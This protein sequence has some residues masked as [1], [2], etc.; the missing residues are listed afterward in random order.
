M[1][2]LIGASN[3]VIVLGSDNISSYFNDASVS[4]NL[5]LKS[6]LATFTD[7]AAEY[8]PGLPGGDV[9][10]TGLYDDTAANIDGILAV[11]FATAASQAIFIGPATAAVGKPCRY[12]AVRAANHQYPIGVSEYTKIVARVEADG[13]LFRGVVHHALTAETTTVNGAAQDNGAASTSGGRVGLWVTAATVTTVTAKY[14][15]SA[16]GSTDWQDIATFTTI[17]GTT[18][19]I[20]SITGTIRR[21]TRFIISAFTG[22]TITPLSALARL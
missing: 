10:L 13:G 3:A 16:D 7:L 18:S 21:Y 8:G 4:R 9:I 2:K 14:Q 15:D 6:D 20:V 19:E 5:N 11:T 12:A 1:A 17:T 22:T